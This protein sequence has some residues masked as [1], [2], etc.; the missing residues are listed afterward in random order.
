MTDHDKVRAFI[1]E[2]FLFGDA[3][4][5]KDDESLR[6]KGIIDSTGILALIAFLEEEFGVSVADN[7]IR[8]ENL[9]TVNRVAAFLRHKLPGVAGEHSLAVN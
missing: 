5:L 8:P 3:A 2:N 7:E 4:G 1:V 6:G 9:D